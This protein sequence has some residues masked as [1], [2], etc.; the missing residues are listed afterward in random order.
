M[1]IAELFAR[2]RALGLDLL[3]ERPGDPAWLRCV[4]GHVDVEF[5]DRVLMLAGQA[6]MALVPLL[7]VSAT[8]V[9]AADGQGLADYFFRR[10]GLAGTAAETMRSLFARPTD[11]VSG[12]SVL[13]VLIVLI[14]VSSFARTLQRMVDRAWRVPYL[15]V[16]GAPYG[17]VA[18]LLIVGGSAVGAWLTSAVDEW[19]PGWVLAVPLHLA[20]T[21]VGWAI[22][23]HLLLSRR[24]PFAALWPGAIYGAVALTAAGWATSIWL[25][26]LIG[27]NSERYGV[28][29][30]AVAL[31]WWLVI[32]AAVLVS[33][34]VVSAELGRDR[35]A[36]RTGASDSD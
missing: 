27:R 8:V 5:R 23:L 11:T 4:R 32:L 14:S 24:V 25:P 31:V 30:V 18:V 36:G 22:V 19:G 7:V 15:G 10:F 9:S 21:V 3:R 6:F 35:A 34:S 33:V 2:A 29:G 20:L 12:T 17:L 26:G 28:I 13:S 1:R 16:R